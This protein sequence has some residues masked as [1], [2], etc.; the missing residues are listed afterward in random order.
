MQNKRKYSFSDAALV[1]HAKDVLN[2]FVDD[3]AD[4]ANFDPDFNATF[5]TLWQDRITSTEDQLT[6]RIL[7]NVQ[8]QYTDAVL[9]AM[10]N[11]RRYY[12]DVKY[13]VKKAFEHQPS[14]WNEF[15]LGS[16]A[17]ARSSQ[18][19]L[20]EFMRDLYNVANKYAAQ[21]NN[22]NFD[23]AK[24]EHINH[25]ANLLDQANREQNS[26]I[27]GKQTI[28]ANRIAT[29]NNLWAILV[30]VA[31]AAQIVYADNKVKYKQYILP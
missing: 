24:I 19:L 9:T 2:L 8:K 1:E 31:E 27:S 23:A 15:G 16:Y 20:I 10:E 5:A 22:V 4:F 17:K 29:Y 13:Y 3:M 11:C 14:I 7:M 12:K 18:P 26:Y 25:L 30:Q 21:L 28:T 6:N